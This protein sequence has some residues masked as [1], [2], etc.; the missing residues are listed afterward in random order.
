MIRHEV[1]AARSTLP[2]GSTTLVRLLSGY[3]AVLESTDALAEADFI[4]AE[5]LGIVDAAQLA[6]LDAVEALL[7]YGQLLC[8]MKDYGAAVVRLREAVRLAEGLDAVDELR[9]QIILA[10]SW[11]SQALA[12]EALGE[13]SQASD[14]LDALTGAKRRIR[15]LAFS[16]WRGS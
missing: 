3:A 1:N 9:R 12:F 13:F 5:A 7:G 6:T 8:T 14:A 10:Q 11:K 15:F 4:R 2:P 16:P